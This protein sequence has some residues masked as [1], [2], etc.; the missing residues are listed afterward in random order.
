M[1][2]SMTQKTTTQWRAWVTVPQPPGATADVLAALPAALP[3][4]GIVAGDGEHLVLQM[5]VDAATMRAA[6]T[7]ALRAARAAIVA[8]TGRAGQAVELP[9]ELRVV[10]VDTAERQAAHPA[11]LE[12]IGTAEAAE[13]LGVSPQR[14]AQLVREHADFPAPVAT[15]RMGPVFTRASVEAFD[16]RWQRRAGRPRTAG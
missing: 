3:G 8:A 7:E 12:L 4:Y 2:P 5:T 14:A 6:A 10:D 13:I 1:S 11:R 15:P 16:R 9:I